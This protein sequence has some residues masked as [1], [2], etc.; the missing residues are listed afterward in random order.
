MPFLCRSG[1]RLRYQQYGSGRA[2]IFLHPIGGRLEDMHSLVGEPSD[3]Q[4]ILLDSR[5]HGGSDLGP[6]DALRFSVFADDVAALL[7]HLGLE[8]AIVGGVSMGAAISLTTALRHPDRVTSLV[9]VRPAWL[10]EPEPGNLQILSEIATAIARYGSSAAA[11]VIQSTDRFREWQQKYPATTESL[12][13]TML[14]SDG[15]RLSVLFRWVP[16]S[17][18]F[19][20][21]ED[22]RNVRV[23]VLIVGND[24]DP[25]HP[26][27][28]AR[29]LARWLPRAAL[30]T[31]P[32]KFDDA[33]THVKAVREHL[34]KFLC[35][36]GHA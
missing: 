21:P 22:L 32:S 11:A 5:G 17:I 9:L 31:V 18:P 16:A 13:R 26:L 12:L 1:V 35:R 19:K 33:S 30:V 25:I 3:T 4:L 15:E 28:V 29:F 24:H 36:N 34:H 8:N 14:S 20:S 23:P 6:V 10:N 2:L 27:P 7:D